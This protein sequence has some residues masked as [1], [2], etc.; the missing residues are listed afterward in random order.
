MGEKNILITMAAENVCMLS[1]FNNKYL[2]VL[3]I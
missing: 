1:V 2:M 3:E